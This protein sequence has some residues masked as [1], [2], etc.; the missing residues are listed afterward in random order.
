LD[1]NHC[2]TTEDDFGL[3]VTKGMEKMTAEGKQFIN[4]KSHHPNMTFKSILFGKAT[5]LRQR[6]QRKDFLTSLNRL[7]DKPIR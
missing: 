6:H 4:G 5:R 7:K 1:V 3:V 2:I